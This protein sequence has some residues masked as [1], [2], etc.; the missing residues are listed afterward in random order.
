MKKRLWAVFLVTMFSAAAVTAVS[1]AEVV[2]YKSATCGCCK[3]WVEHMRANGF[4]VKAHDVKDV[5]TYKTRF[6][7]PADLGSCHTATVEGYAI[8]GHVPAKEVKRLLAEKPKITGLAVP[9]MP[10]GSPGMDDSGIKQP[11]EVIAFDKNGSRS[12]YARY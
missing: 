6:G 9:N 5:V 1:A 2:V 8:E 11:Y 12:I 4:D 10:L 7:V 3:K